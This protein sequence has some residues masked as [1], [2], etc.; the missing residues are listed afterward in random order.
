MKNEILADCG[1]QESVRLHIDCFTFLSCQKKATASATAEFVGGILY[2][3]T[4]MHA[5]ITGIL[6]GL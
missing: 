6:V 2:P 3:D 1:D 4:T 5:Q